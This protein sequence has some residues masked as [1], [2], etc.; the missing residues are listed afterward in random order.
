MVLFLKFLIT[1]N[2]NNVINNNKLLIFFLFY[3]S[4]CFVAMNFFQV[5]NLAIQSTII[6]VWIFFQ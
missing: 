2:N 3:F 1:D 4:V 5:N 6:E